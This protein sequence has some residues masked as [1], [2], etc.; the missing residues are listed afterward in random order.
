MLKKYLTYLRDNPNRYWFKRK[1]YGWGWVPVTLQ[2][3]MVVGLWVVAVALFARTLDENSSPQE[4]AFT[5]IL[6]ILFLTIL[7]I[8]ICYKKGEKPRWQWGLDK[9]IN[10]Y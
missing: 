10:R 9:K 2:G 7:L 1:L 3:W 6:P 5:C 4:V 8:H